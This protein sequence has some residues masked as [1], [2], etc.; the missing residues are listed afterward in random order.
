MAD[1]VEKDESVVLL[2]Q[3][4]ATTGEILKIL[5]DERKVSFWYIMERVAVIV[6]VAGVYSILYDIIQRIL[7]GK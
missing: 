4:T 7:G 2:R 3:L 6:A 1:I 5:K